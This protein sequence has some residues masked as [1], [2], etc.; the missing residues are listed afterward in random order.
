VEVPDNDHVFQ[1]SLF[2]STLWPLVPWKR[3]K[4]VTSKQEAALRIQKVQSCNSGAGQRRR[5]CISR[6]AAAWILTRVYL[7]IQ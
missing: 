3:K 5:A 1:G 4:E 7:S 6:L 2:G